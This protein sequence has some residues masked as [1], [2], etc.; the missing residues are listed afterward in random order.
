MIFDGYPLTD[1]LKAHPENFSQKA[2]VHFIET[3]EKWLGV[4]MLIP[5]AQAPH[6]PLELVEL[7]TLASRMKSTGLIR[8]MPHKGRDVHDEPHVYR[9]GVLHNEAE[10]AGGMSRH[11][12]YRALLTALAEAAERSLWAHETDYFDTPLEST[13]QALQDRALATHRFAG[14][15]EHQSATIPLLMRS[16]QDSF[17]W[18]KGKSWT[19]KNEIYVP[20]QIVSKAHYQ[21]IRRE[22]KEPVIR[23]AITTGLATGPTRE[24]ALLAGALEVIERD[25][26]MILWL[27]QL[28]APRI[29]QTQLIQLNPRLEELLESCAKYRLEV[30]FVRMITDAPTFALL[31]VV[32]DASDQPP[33]TVGTAAHSNGGVAAEKALLEALRA[34]TNAQHRVV[35]HPEMLTKEVSKLAHWERGVYWANPVHKKQLDFLTAGELKPLPTEEWERDSD[36]EHFVRIV[37]WCKKSGYEL[38]SVSLSD[39]KKNVTP[40]KI[41]FVIIPELQPLYQTESLRALGGAR[42]TKVPQ[43]YGFTPRTEPYS[44]VPHPFV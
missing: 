43:M 32:R 27:N 7:F 33:C 3:L 28:S 5:S 24:F 36:T 37:S 21:H 12:E 16:P 10:S 20:A 25:A 11:S 38:V 19:T 13:E 39:A 35:N 30:D 14:F 22:K 17:L 9:W 23:I 44:A 1:V 29:P 42:L 31:A 26:F 40:W 4:R 2:Q 8:A 41:E 18:V 6:V 15:S 34:R